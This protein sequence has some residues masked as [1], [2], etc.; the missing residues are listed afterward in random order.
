MTSQIELIRGDGMS[1]AYYYAL[2]Q[3]KQNDL[4]RLQ[5]CNGQLTNKQGEF[6][7]NAYL[8]MEPKLTAST[9]KGQL[10]SHFDQIRIDG[11]LASFEEIQTSQFSRVF[12]V[13]NSKMAEIAMEIE[14]IKATIARLE[15][16]AARERARA[17]AT[18]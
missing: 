4:R 17:G 1:L 3:K 6:A 14:S 7:S 8:M 9:W 18:K 11:I 16:E 5:T 13:L 12:S 15:A 10:A 2:L